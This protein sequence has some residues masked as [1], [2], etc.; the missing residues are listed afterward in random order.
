MGGSV[1]GSPDEGGLRSAVRSV[2]GASLLAPLAVSS[3]AIIGAFWS[4]LLVG[5]GGENCAVSTRDPWEGVAFLSSALGLALIGGG[6]VTMII[7]GLRRDGLQLLISGV[8]MI[9]AVVLL[10]L[11]A[12]SA[13]FLTCP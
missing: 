11:V 10:V 5:A 8:L 9:F 2:A 12:A 1:A 6:C 7:L 3:Y 4:K 13:G